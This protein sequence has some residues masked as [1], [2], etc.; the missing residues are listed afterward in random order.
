MYNLEIMNNETK[1]EF[2]EIKDFPTY[3]IS[4][5]G[6]VLRIKG[7]KY[8]YLKGGLNQFGYKQVLLYNRK[9][10]M[11][12]VHKLVAKYFLPN[13]YNLTDIHHIDGNKTNNDVNNL[14]WVSKAN[15]QTKHRIMYKLCNDLSILAW[16]NVNKS[17]KENLNYAKENNIKVSRTTLYNFCDR[18]GINPKGNN[19]LKTK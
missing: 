14:Q 2:K 17:V 9:P 16:Y 11:H 8:Y 1:E 7:N 15:H 5:K 3:F 4:N 6:R 10:K 18:N 19:K 13:P 12:R